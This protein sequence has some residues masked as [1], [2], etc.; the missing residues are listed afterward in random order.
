[1]NLWFNCQ[2]IAKLLHNLQ[3]TVG[4]TLVFFTF[5]SYN[6]SGQSGRSA[7]IKIS[8]VVFESD[9][10][11]P[12]PNA[13]FQVLNENMAGL[14]NQLGRFEI[15]VPSGDTLMFTYVGYKDT[16]FEVKDTLNT[17]DYVVGV[18]MSRDTIQI[19]EVVVYPRRRDLRQDFMS[20]KVDQDLQ[21][22][23][24]KRNIIISSNQGISGK[25]V[26][27]DSDE[28]YKMISRKRKMDA[29][30][31]GMIAPDQ[32]VGISFLVLIP[33]AIYKLSHPDEKMSPDDIYISESEYEILLNNYKTQLKKRSFAITDSV[34]MLK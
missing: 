32:M 2:R 29:M 30:N 26:L 14:T 15:F 3:I 20:I 34:N 5:F 4:F 6:L 13:H 11:I 28:A 7:S 23:N 31:Q 25:Q 10:L 12:L 1:M 17:G 24:A 22:D 8:G 21:L 16:Y 19:R 27:W 18:F 33:Y 9:S